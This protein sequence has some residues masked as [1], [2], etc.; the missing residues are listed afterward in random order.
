[1]AV[2]TGS[3]SKAF[4]SRTGRIG[5][6][7]DTRKY[8]N[9]TQRTSPSQIPNALESIIPRAKE[10]GRVKGKHAARSHLFVDVDTGATLQD[11]DLGKSQWRVE[12]DTL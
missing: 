7:P 1:M 4:S 2:P 9:L 11:L 8:E 6:L 5:L 3:G 12:D 10:R